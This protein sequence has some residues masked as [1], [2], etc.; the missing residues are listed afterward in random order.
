[1]TI[2][3]HPADQHD[4]IKVRGARVNNLKD[5]DVDIPKR[6]LNVFTG[7]SG[8]GKS[9]L[10]FGTVAAESRRLIDETYST[11]IQGFMPTL[12]RPE[13][14]SLENLSPA[15]VIDQERMGANSRSTVG[16]ATDAH[17]ILRLL[18]SRLS[19][20]HVGTSS[21]FSFNLPDGWCPSC[22]GSGQAA[23]LDESKIIDEA[24]SLQD[25]AISA[26]GHSVGEWYWK[27]YGETGLFKTDLPIRDFSEQD[28]DLLLYAPQQKIKVEGKNVTY[29]G[30]IT[31]VRR[32]WIDRPDPPKAKQIVNFVA[33]IA[34]TSTCPDCAGSRL[35][36]A[37]RTATVHGKT[38]AELSAMQVDELTGFVAGLDLAVGPARDNLLGILRS[39]VEIGLG[40]LSLDR[41]AGTLSGGEAQRV[42]MIRHLGSPLS[43]VT[44]V[45]DEPTIGLHPHD[46]ARMNSLLHN[47][48]DKGNTVLVVEHKP[49]VIKAADNIIDIGPGS[50]TD[51][52]N[53]VFYGTPA[54]LATSDSLTAQYLNTSLELAQPRVAA[55]E[56]TVEHVSR[57]NVRDVDVTFPLGVLTAVTGVAGSGKSSLVTAALAGRNDVLVVDQS[58]IRGSRRSNPATYTGILDK[59]RTKFAKDNG[60]KPALFSANSEGA[61]PTCK[62]LGVVYVD[63]SFTAGVSTTCEECGGKRFKEEVLQYKVAG[64]DIS[65]V[66]D[67]SVAQA[68]EVFRAGEV[69]KVLKR[70]ISVGLPYLKLGQPLTTLSGGERQRLKLA[71]KMTEKAPIIVL[72]EPT[73]GLHLADTETLITMMHDLVASG[74]TVIAIEHNLAVMAAADHIIDVGPSAGHDGG[75]IVFSGSPADMV[76]ADTITAEYLR[77]ATL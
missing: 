30:L 49:E 33:D 10:V 63:L 31:R 35:K 39:M 76:K 75:S 26:P 17:A 41:E 48:R 18:F 53:V 46:I 20:P 25:G 29:E 36:L 55:G 42:K 43:D 2:D 58:A 59:I 16:T 3:A 69:N 52:G 70:L 40:Y 68:V 34:T 6:R 22:E 38:I 65:E 74:R 45:F 11:F 61:C 64:R 32:L 47:I 66:L 8:S 73:S 9:S 62:G 54:E 50:G 27:T 21:A 15:I 13:V 60:V 51:G 24:K 23:T 1:M 77:K 19:E 56:L 12:P 67:M 44:Y 37:A 5:V 7:V 4:I 71:A 14:D 28:R 72:D 57:N